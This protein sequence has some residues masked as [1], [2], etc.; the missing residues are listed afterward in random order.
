MDWFIRVF[1]LESY[2]VLLRGIVGMSIFMTLFITLLFNVY[3]L[4]KE[5][6]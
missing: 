4:G 6:A 2:S 1:W 3:H 5:N